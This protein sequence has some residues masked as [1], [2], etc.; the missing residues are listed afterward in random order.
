MCFS[1][2]QHGNNYVTFDTVSLVPYDRKLIDTSLLSP[3]QVRNSL[4]NRLLIEKLLEIHHNF[5]LLKGGTKKGLPNTL[6]KFPATRYN[7]SSLPQRYDQFPV[8]IC[9][10]FS[11]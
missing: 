4:Y 11:I 2:P 6:Q 1:F 5:F 8:L 3:E 10:F 9:K 7:A